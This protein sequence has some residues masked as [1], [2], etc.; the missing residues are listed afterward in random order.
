M[1]KALTYFMTYIHYT[2]T[3]K[4]LPLE[5]TEFSDIPGSS[6]VLYRILAIQYFL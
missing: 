1:E 3:V 4:V 5:N 2:I 6:G